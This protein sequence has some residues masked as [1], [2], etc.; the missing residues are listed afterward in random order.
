MRLPPT[1]ARLDAAW[2]ADALNRADAI[3][4]A[5]PSRPH[6][7]RVEPKGALVQRFA[8]PLE[9][10]LPQNRTRHGKPWEL[11]K[12]KRDLGLLMFLQARGRR[13]AALPG[14]PFVRCVRFSSVETDAYSDWA[15]AAVDR[16][17]EKHDGLG[18]LRDDRPADVEIH[19]WSEYVPPRKGFCLVEVFAGD[20]AAVVAPR[21]AKR[22]KRTR[23]A[24]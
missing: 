20:P 24:A 3:L 4:A 17:T 11:G 19:Q 8:L 1:P 14:R 6:L 15:K 12:V 21:P 13:R 10:C 9:L 2:I 7:V 23:R 5:P 16:L 22:P 18:Y